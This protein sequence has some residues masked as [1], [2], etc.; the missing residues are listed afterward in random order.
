MVHRTYKVRLGELQRR[1]HASAQP[2]YQPCTGANGPPDVQGLCPADRSAWG[3]FGPR[4]CT[5]TPCNAMWVLESPLGSKI[6]RKGYFWSRFKA[7]F[8][9]L[10]RKDAI[11][12]ITEGETKLGLYPRYFLVKKRGGG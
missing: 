12:E 2:V 7:S 9:P 5:K 8:Q 11:E 3:L 6:H 4:E 10:P 1:A